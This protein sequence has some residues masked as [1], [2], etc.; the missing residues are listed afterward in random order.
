[1]LTNAAPVQALAISPDEHLLVGSGEGGPRLWDLNAGTCRATNF[2]AGAAGSIVFSPDS[3]WYAAGSDATGIA[4]HSAEDGHILRS[5]WAP[6]RS[7]HLSIAAAPGGRRL[8]IGTW[9]QRFRQYDVETGIQ[10]Y[11]PKYAGSI[12]DPSL[13]FGGSYSPDGRLIM[14]W[15]QDGTVRLFEVNQG[16]LEFPPLH[17]S[18]PVTAAVFSPESRRLATAG[19]DGLVKL[20]DLATD[21]S[22]GPSNVYLRRVS[23]FAWS[24]KG[25]QLLL[26]HYDATAEVIRVPSGTS[27]GLLLCPAVDPH[28]DLLGAWSPS[29][30]LLAL[31]CAGVLRFWDADLF[32]PVGPEIRLFSQETYKPNFSRMVA[33]SC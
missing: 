26:S 23:D 10:L 21:E 2:V 7:S 29:G 11:G 25:I 14:T 31:A 15:L 1:V 13:A 27:S 17:H 4:I 33:C 9:D 30:D 16:A 12:E 8:L 20:W 5:I 18:G 6:L 22:A 19:R 3:S 24:P 32:N 28:G